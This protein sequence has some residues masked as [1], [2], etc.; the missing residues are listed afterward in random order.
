VIDPDA[1]FDMNIPAHKA[2]LQEQIWSLVFAA[3]LGTAGLF[4]LAS[5]NYPFDMLGAAAFGEAMMLV[6]IRS[7]T[8]LL[9]IIKHPAVFV[10]RVAIM[11]A[12][13]SAT[14]V[15]FLEGN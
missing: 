6:V 14:V 9:P 2:W 12:V 8:R 13:A 1:P 15:Y 10:L 5:F 3:S 11:L 4:T 7:I